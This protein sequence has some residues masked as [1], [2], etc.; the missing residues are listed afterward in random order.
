MNIHILSTPDE[1]ISQ[2]AE[3]IV[4]LANDTITS[5]GRFNIA[6]SGGNSPRKLYETLASSPLSDEFPW[7]NTYFFFGDE[8]YVPSDDPDNNAKMAR[9]AMLTKMSV[10]ADHIFAINTA[11]SPNEAANDYSHRILEHFKLDEPAFDLILLGLGDD[12]HTASLFPHT[13]V[14][15]ETDALVKEV[16]MLQ[17]HSWR[18]SFTRPLINKARKIFFM[19]FGEKKAEAVWQV[20]EGDQYEFQYPAQFVRPV[21]GEVSWYVDEAAAGLLRNR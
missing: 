15:A 2:I 4:T 11:H 14:L 20:L 1:V 3:D 7:E 9:E 12:A 5:R 13:R 21:S 10:P 6:L 17:D 18:I 16:K 8:R 19:T